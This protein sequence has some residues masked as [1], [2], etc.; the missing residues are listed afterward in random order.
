MWVD[1]QLYGGARLPGFG[2]R[3]LGAGD[4]RVAILRECAEDLVASEA[5]IV[6]PDEARRMLEV[7]RA[8][9]AV[10]TSR[11]A[12]KRIGP[13]AHIYGA[14]ILTLL[15]AAPRVVP[16]LVAFARFAGAL[17]RTEEYLAHNRIFRPLDRYVGPAERRY[18]PLEAR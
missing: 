2:H 1:A 13:N 3:F 4:P 8:I 7:A 6:E 9:D 18:V 10:G 14:L 15:G 16:F 17:A 5:A 12:P 11:L